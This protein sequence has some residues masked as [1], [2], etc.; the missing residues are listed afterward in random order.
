WLVLGVIGL[1]L[2][3]PRAR[4]FLLSAAAI[5]GVAALK[6]REIGLSIHTVVPLLPL[7]ALGLG[8][9]LDVGLRSLYGLSLAWLTHV[10]AFAPRRVAPVDRGGNLGSKA[11]ERGPARRQLRG[12]RSGNVVAVGARQQFTA[13]NL[14]SSPLATHLPRLGAALV[15]FLVIVAP[16]ALTLATDAAGLATTFTTRQDEILA[17]PQDAEAVRRYVAA[18]ARPDDLVLASPAIAWMFD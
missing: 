12:G 9:M 18:H 4:G 16:V 2:A 5:L 1:F 8:I 6:V 7:L 14:G 3:P 11:A 17:A 13:A 10:F 15:V